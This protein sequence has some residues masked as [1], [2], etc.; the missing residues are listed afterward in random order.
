M[1]NILLIYRGQVFSSEIKPKLDEYKNNNIVLVVENDLTKHNIKLLLKGYE[2]KIKIITIE[3]FLNTGV[4][5]NMIKKMRTGF[6]FKI[7][8]PPYQLGGMENGGQNKIYNQISKKT[9]SLPGGKYNDVTE[10]ITPTS[11]LKR[12]KRFSLIG[13]PGFN[14]VDFTTDGAFKVG[15]DICS[16]RVDKRNQTEKVE[17]I[18][19]NGTE[20]FDRNKVIFDTSVNDKNF[21]NLYHIL[22]EKTDT[23]E[24]RMFQQNNF[25]PALNKNKTNEH[26]YK[27]YKLIDGKPIE[28]YFSSRIPYNLGVEKISIGMTKSLNKNSIFIGKLDFDP[29]YMNTSIESDEES[30]N[31]KSFIL[32]D[33]FTQ[34]SDKWKKVDGYGY[35]YALKHLPPFDKTKSWTNEEVKEFI[36]SFV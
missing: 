22:K 30:N 25:G 5:D 7:G 1:K 31:I 21:M 15:V 8:N 34:H 27:L 32:S 29:G 28:T 33:Y 14:K 3:E 9:L 2:Q 36:E 18:N 12:S 11:V 10:L 4:I 19:K 24:K 16:W 26:I 35:N 23:P 13:Q 17:V 6:D 20:Y